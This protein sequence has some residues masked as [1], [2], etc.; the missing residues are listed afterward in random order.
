MMG[1]SCSVDFPIWEIDSD[2]NPGR[3]HIFDGSNFA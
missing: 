1:L 2:R 3:V